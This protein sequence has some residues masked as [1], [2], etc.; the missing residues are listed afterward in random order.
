MTYTEKLA[1]NN[2]NGCRI[3]AWYPNHL[4]RVDLTEVCYWGLWKI[5][6]LV[7]IDHFSRKV[8]AVTPLEGPTAGREI[9]SLEMVFENSG[10][11]KHRIS[12]QGNV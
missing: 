12:D 10:K 4:W 3:T 8:V 11:P 7:A 5:Y 9:D 6:V 2:E 1:A